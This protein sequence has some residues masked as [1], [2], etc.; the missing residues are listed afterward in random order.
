MQAKL[1]RFT[2]GPMERASLTFKLEQCL[3]EIFLNTSRQRRLLTASS[4]AE[5]LAFAECLIL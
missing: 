2:K 5:E 4:E 3:T 1:L